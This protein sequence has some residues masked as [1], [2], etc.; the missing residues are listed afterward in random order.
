[1][2]CLIPGRRR[3]LDA[4]ILPAATHLHHEVERDGAGLLHGLGENLAQVVVRWRIWHGGRLNLGAGPGRELHDAVRTE[5]EGRGTE[6]LNS[7]GIGD[8][9]G[10]DAVD[11]LLR[12]QDPLDG[13]RPD[14][15]VLDVLEDGLPVWCRKRGI[16]R[17][18]GGKEPYRVVPARGQDPVQPEIVLRVGEREDG[19]V[20]HQEVLITRPVVLCQHL[21]AHVQY[22]DGHATAAM[23]VGF[24]RSL[25]PSAAVH[26]GALEGRRIRKPD[27]RGELPARLR[28]QPDLQFRR[29]IGVDGEAGLDAAV[30]FWMHAPEH[31]LWRRIALLQERDSQPG[32]F[33][34]LTGFQVG[35]LDVLE[36]A[37]GC[38][39]RHGFTP[40]LARDAGEI[41][42]A[43][44]LARCHE[45]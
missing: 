26:I 15:L 37:E 13:I 23:L 3:V 9:R 18:Q 16:L 33:V 2:C 24:R 41:R 6:V 35:V 29:N 43:L 34:N 21:V 14:V 28:E 42:L 5:E 7:Q 22:F 20:D 39:G 11:D 17:P 12:V 4:Q 40:D 36:R 44:G 27:D 45:F 19:L 10:L 1:M 8:R 25:L 32:R 30:R 31:R 38:A